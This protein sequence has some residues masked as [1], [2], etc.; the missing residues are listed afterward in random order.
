VASNVER[1]TKTF[2]EVA[3]QAGLRT[4]VTNWWATWP[5][6]PSSGTVISDRAVLRLEH[7]GVL[8]AEIAPVGLYEGLKIKW[9]AL[10]AGAI[11]EASTFFRHRTLRELPPLPL[12]LRAVL[13]RSAE[14]DGFVARLAEATDDRNDLLALYLP[15]LDIV[16]HTL[17]GNEGTSPSEVDQRLGALRQ[18]YDYVG[19]LI[20][21]TIVRLHDRGV[22]FLIAQPGRLHRGNGVLAA[23]GPGIRPTRT[24]AAVLDVAPTILHSLGVPVARD[25]EGKVIEGLF[26]PEFLKKHPVRFVKGYGLK[27]IVPQSTTGQPLDAE[28]IER[29]RSLGYIR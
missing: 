8:D 18:Y 21:E 10:R 14:L 11:N 17:F 19:S 2:W 26:E 6:D 9:P 15:G 16:Q 5:A 7:G 3:G 1:R 22:V 13:T 29:L 27:G 25:L 4:S 24:T 23:R 12:E 20:A 28:A